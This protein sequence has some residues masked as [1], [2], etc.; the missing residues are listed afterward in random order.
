[1]DELGKKGRE[2][3]EVNVDKLL[4]ELN[5]AR[6]D[7]WIAHYY[8]KWAADIACG[9]NF[10]PVADKLDEIAKDEAEHFDEL[11]ERIIELGGEPEK[12]FEDLVKIANAPK[13]TF[14]KDCHDLEGILKAVIEQGER[15]A[16][17]VYNKILKSLGSC[18]DKD[19]RTFHLIQHILT[20][21]IE[22]EEAFENFL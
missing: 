19:A 7:E 1:V 6:A 5:K 18:F 9:I 22:H 2:I 3:V 14:P 20:E 21:E 10:E 11:T 8:Y 13:I 15:G 12:D 16:I 4:E 17:E